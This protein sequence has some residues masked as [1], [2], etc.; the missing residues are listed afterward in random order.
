[1][2]GWARGEGAARVWPT[3]RPSVR[4]EPPGLGGLRNLGSP[5]APG[6]CHLGI[7]NL[8]ANNRD[9]GLNRQVIEQSLTLSSSERAELAGL[10]LE[11]LEAP[12]AGCDQA[13][14]AAEL[15]RRLERVEA[16]TEV[17]HERE[18]MI[19]ELRAAI[20]RRDHPRA[21]STRPG[22]RPGKPQPGT[23]PSA[24]GWGRSLWRN[25][26]ADLP[27]CYP[28][29]ARCITDASTFSAAKYS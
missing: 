17:W 12:G 9:M 11:S 22:R 21:S 28:T 29:P 23:S 24:S 4:Y 3:E 18:Q 1:V 20:G 10:L 27:C 15:E 26:T 14:L 13:G 2:V 7:S 8:G 25:W 16:G 6:G 5:Q 19:R